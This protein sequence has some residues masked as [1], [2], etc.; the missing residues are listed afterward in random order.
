MTEEVCNAFP[1]L[2]I[3]CMR[4][5]T[6]F[7]VEVRS[8][9]SFLSRR[10]YSYVGGKKQS[11]PLSI[12]PWSSTKADPTL[13][14][15]W[16]AFPYTLPTDT[17]KRGCRFKHLSSSS[18]VPPSSQLLP[19]SPTWLSPGNIRKEH[20]L[21]GNTVHFRAW[22]FLTGRPLSNMLIWEEMQDGQTKC[23]NIFWS[24]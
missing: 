3:R 4:V 22:L 12:N 21:K 5:L 10:S 24:F 16:L 11:Q 14:N 17:L 13:N 6:K 9:S 7:C 18:N 1:V 8:S 23:W 19:D 20:P 15:T 2:C